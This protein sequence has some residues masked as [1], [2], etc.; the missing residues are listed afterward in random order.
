MQINRQGVKNSSAL[1]VNVM[2]FLFTL[3]NKKVQM[4]KS[5]HRLKKHSIHIFM[6][7]DIRQI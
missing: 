3:K 1:G 7:L 6:Q 4:Q 5:I 2:D